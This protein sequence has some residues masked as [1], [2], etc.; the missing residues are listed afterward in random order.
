[1]Q[2]LTRFTAAASILILTSACSNQAV[3]NNLQ[4]YEINRCLRESVN[5]HSACTHEFRETF[6]EYSKKRQQL[7]DRRKISDAKN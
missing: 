7:L 6:D 1:M 5:M 2:K 3:Y 4:L